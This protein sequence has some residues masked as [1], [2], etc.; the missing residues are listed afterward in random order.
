MRSTGPETQDTFFSAAGR[1]FEALELM[2]GWTDWKVDLWET[3]PKAKT[4]AEAIGK[5]AREE[6]DRAAAYGIALAPSF[7]FGG[8]GP[9]SGKLETRR[10]PQFQGETFNPETGEFEKQ[11]DR[12]ESTSTP[13]P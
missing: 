6:I 7:N 1:H 3:D 9:G 12:F 5:A 8:S 11:H 13:R 4:H 2:I 10:M